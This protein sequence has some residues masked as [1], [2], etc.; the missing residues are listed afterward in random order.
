MY[1]LRHLVRF[2]CWLSAEGC[3]QILEAVP[4]LGS[5]RPSSKPAMVSR[6]FL[7]LNLSDPLFHF[8]RTLMIRL[9]PP[10]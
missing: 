4:V 7:M 10:G 5:L 3:S 6:V 8:L 2:S 9:G 1:L